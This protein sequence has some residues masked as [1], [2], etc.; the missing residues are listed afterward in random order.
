MV[1]NLFVCLCILAFTLLNGCTSTQT[2]KA[3]SITQPLTSHE[4]IVLLSDVLNP[5]VEYTDKE[6]NDCLGKWMREFNP[7]LKF[8]SA[9][10]F[11]DEL[12]PYFSASTQPHTIEEYQSLLNKRLVR[13]RIKAIQVRYLI[14]QQEAKTSSEDSHGIILPIGGPQAAGFF[15]LLWWNRQTVF[16]ANIWDMK[17]GESKGKIDVHAEGTGILP[18]FI[19]PIP[20]YLPA[21]EKASCKELA[22]HI[23]SALPTQ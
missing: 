14:V 22:K 16:N 15:G 20:L 12:Y 23:T 6:V 3:I 17:T 18:A 2:E 21:T 4:G 10:E 5:S 8:V 1:N 9:N 13:E 11:R 7:K 19:L